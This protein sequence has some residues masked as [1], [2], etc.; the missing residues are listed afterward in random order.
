M[1]YL[2]SPFI[3]DNLTVVENCT[4]GQDIRAN[5]QL[6]YSTDSGIFNATCDVN[7]TE[8][9]NGWCNYNTIDS[10]NIS[11]ECPPSISQIGGENVTVS[12]TAIN[13]VGRSNSTMSRSSKYI[14]LC[15]E[16]ST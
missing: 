12:V 1:L 2:T 16:F 6:F 7:G 10:N 13:L 5:Y 15:M 14:C 4:N 9:S 11:N 8:C 3:Q